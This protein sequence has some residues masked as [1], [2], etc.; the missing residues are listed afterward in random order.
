MSH[1]EQGKVPSVQRALH[2]YH[3]LSESNTNLRQ[4]I[5]L[6]TQLL[7]SEKDTEVGRSMLQLLQV[8]YTA[9]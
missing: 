2:L 4:P 5:G 9:Q 1:A 7:Q 8:D 6:E 3:I